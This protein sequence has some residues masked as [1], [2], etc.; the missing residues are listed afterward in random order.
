MV[1]SATRTSVSVSTAELLAAPGSEVP[2][3]AVTVAVF[4]RLPAALERRLAT[5]V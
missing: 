2:A 5:S 4:A 1:R 3:A